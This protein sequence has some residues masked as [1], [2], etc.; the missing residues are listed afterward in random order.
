MPERYQYSISV[1]IPT[2]NRPDRLLDCLRS[3]AGSSLPREEFE[4]VVVDDGSDPPA[5]QFT[6]QLASELNL[7]FIRQKNSGPAAARN[8]GAAEATGQYLAFTDDDCRPDSNWLSEV[9]QYLQGTPDVLVG[10]RTPN[11]VKNN[12]YTLASQV[13]LD[14]VYAFF[15]SRPDKA[16]FFASNNIALDRSR[17]LEIGGF[18]VTF[19]LAAAEDRDFCDRWV[20]SG[21]E[22]H[23]VP[24]AVVMHFH[25]MTLRKFWRQQYNYGRGA[26]Q[27]HQLR[28]QRKSGRMWDD[29]RMHTQLPALLRTSLRSL[30]IRTRI[31]V[32]ALLALWQVANTLGYFRERL[33]RTKAT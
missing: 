3:L 22:L 15:N 21:W 7:R 25:H 30:G 10:G 11:G 23:S 24:S 9:L 28:H 19:P 6:Q 1:V 31:Q 29:T 13:I 2:Y 20:H 14:V 12:V 8:R 18:D 5:E 16:R 26:Y 4:V 33:L 17:F 27:Y 32:L